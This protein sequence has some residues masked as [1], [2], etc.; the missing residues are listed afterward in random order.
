MSGFF[1]GMGALSKADIERLIA[2][3]SADTRA[4][5]AAKVAQT[6]G[7]RQLTE[8]ERRL[9][10]EI[11]G[12]MARDAE[13]RVRSALSLNLKEN[14]DVPHDLAVRL[15]RDVAEV[16]TPIL[17]FSAALSDADLLAIVDS[18]GHDHQAAVARREQVSEAV[19]SALVERG[20]EEVVGALMGNRG[21]AIPEQAMGRA[22][23]RFGASETVSAAMVH[24]PKLPIAISERLV[25][26]VSETLRDHLVTHHELPADTAADLLLQTRERALIG[27]LA[28]GQSSQDVRSLIA[29]L[30]AN[31]RLTSTL[32]LRALCTGDVDFFEC[33]LAQLAGVP[34]QNAHQLI[35]DA[36]GRGLEALYLRGGQPRELLPMVRAAVD[37]ANELEYD[38]LPGDRP[39]FVET[40]IERVLTR[41]ED[42]AET[43]DVD[44]L[45]TRLSRAQAAQ[46]SAARS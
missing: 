7:D 22:I 33:G 32:L 42:M 40:V 13:V 8:A 12:V 21:A 35:S 20:D 25:A 6:F 44:W 2:D 4:D 19:A 29:E 3:P 39:R 27:L 41:F 16:A 23:D 26:L 45:I 38:G 24:R 11:L 1:D 28:E 18:A 30:H 14:P 10:T 37:V 17:Q 36:G 43:D 15:A 46:G 5:T 34:V 9:A 31:G